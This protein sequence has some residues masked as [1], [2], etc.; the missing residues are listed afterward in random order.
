MTERVIS[1]ILHGYNSLC[2]IVTVTFLCECQL[3]ELNLKQS[4]D[5]NLLGNIGDFDIKGEGLSGQIEIL[6]LIIFL[7]IH[8]GIVG[9]L[10]Q[11]K[12]HIVCV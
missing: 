1:A 5:I 3:K 9:L 2:K 6:V 12:Y 10:S 4:A 11:I 8:Y 7:V